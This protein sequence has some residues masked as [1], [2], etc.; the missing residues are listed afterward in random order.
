MNKKDLVYI[1]I[2]LLLLIGGFLGNQY[3][4][5]LIKAEA[6]AYK[7]EVLKN[8]ILIKVNKTQSTKLVDDTKTIRDLE[9]VIKDLGIKLEEKPKTITKIVYVPKSIDK[10]IDNIEVQG[11]SIFITDSYPNKEDP[12]ILYTTDFNLKTKEGLS[13]W[14]FNP[15]NMSITLSQREDGIWKSDIKAPEF[16]NINEFEII[17]TPLDIPKIDNFGWILGAGYGKDFEQNQNYIKI[18]GGFR[19]KKMYL[20]VG[21]GT[22]KTIDTTIKFEF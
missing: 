9:K 16:I 21:G 20:D 10:P 2:I 4:N 12:F 1:I 15:I 18:S 5:K 8:D 13:T 11:D 6:K 14:N 3:Y 22:N 19:Y 17:S 7:E